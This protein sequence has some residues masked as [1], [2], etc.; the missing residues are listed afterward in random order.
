MTQLTRIQ[1]GP[2][3]LGKLRPGVMRPLTDDELGILLDTDL[4][5]SPG[6]TAAEDDAADR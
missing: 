1:V 3:K 2:V 5:A 6:E 4:P